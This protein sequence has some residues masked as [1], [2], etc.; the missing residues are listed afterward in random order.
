MGAGHSFVLLAYFADPERQLKR[1][2]NV[3]LQYCPDSEGVQAALL[4]LVEKADP[5]RTSALFALTHFKNPGHRELFLG[6]LQSDQAETARAALRG[7]QP[8]LEAGDLA[9]LQECRD[10]WKS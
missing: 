4:G 6:Y 2:M 1:E 3:A 9:A 10:R 8:H 7:L 5:L